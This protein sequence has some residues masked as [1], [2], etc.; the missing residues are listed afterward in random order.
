M[1]VCDPTTT[2]TTTTTTTTTIT[3]TTTTTYTEVVD[4]SPSPSNQRQYPSGATTRPVLSSLDLE[5]D[6]RGRVKV[7]TLLQSITNPDVFVLGDN[8]SVEGG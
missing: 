3:T 8:A 4:R 5:K 1:L 6:G 2:I 7:D